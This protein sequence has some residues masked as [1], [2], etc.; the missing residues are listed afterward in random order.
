MKFE[1][2]KYYRHTTGHELAILCEAE[3]T[4]RGKGLVAET[5]NPKEELCLVGMSE[6]HAV[7]YTEITKE[8]WMKNF[9]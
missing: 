9:S 7:N 3:T 1:V 4:I 2:G 5:N 6:K 8:E